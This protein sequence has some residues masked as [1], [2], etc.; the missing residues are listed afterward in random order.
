MG[1]LIAASAVEN[2]WSG[3]LIN[4]AVRDVDEIA[5]MRL[6]VKA[7]NATPM[8]T[9]RKGVGDTDL[10]VSFAGVEFIPGHFVYADNNG[11][12]VASKRLV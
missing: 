6:G 4:G 11:V 2:G 10:A 3:V 1:D 9:E 7:L 8:K 5:G 12:I